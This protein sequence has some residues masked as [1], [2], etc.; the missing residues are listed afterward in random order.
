MDAV[1][2]QNAVLVEQASAAGQALNEQ[3]TDLT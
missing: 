3:A 2:Q 1:T